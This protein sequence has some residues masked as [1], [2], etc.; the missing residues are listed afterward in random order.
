MMTE[1][2]A[3]QAEAIVE[4]GTSAV[5]QPDI[6][7]EH[8]TVTDVEPRVFDTGATEAI[9]GAGT[10]DE[11]ASIPPL[12]AAY[13][14]PASGWAPPHTLAGKGSFSGQVSGPSRRPA[15]TATAILLA[16]ASGTMDGMSWPIDSRSGRCPKKCE[17]ASNNQ[18]C[19]HIVDI[20]VGDE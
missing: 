17:T 4:A 19:S 16:R 9:T 6:G 10:T 3:Q 12:P 11:E 5:T 1:P 8:V 13:Q 18:L 15:G 20:D 14:W 7:A 2:L